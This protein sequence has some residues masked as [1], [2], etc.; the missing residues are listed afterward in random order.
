MIKPATD[1]GVAEVPL[2]EWTDLA[3][4][5]QAILE[6]QAAIPSDTLSL[7]HGLTSLPLEPPQRFV[8]EPYVA[9]DRC[10]P[11]HYALRSDCPGTELRRVV[12]I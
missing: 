12:L 1:S 7:P 2:T 10:Y 11:Y 9:T 8:A 3:L 5:S 4:Y 6:R